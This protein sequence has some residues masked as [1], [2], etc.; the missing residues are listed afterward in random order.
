MSRLQKATLLIILIIIADQ[1][2]K[3]WVKTHMVEGSS[4]HVFGNWF[5]ILFTENEGAAFGW[6]VGGKVGKLLLSIIRVILAGA[7]IWYLPRLVKKDVSMGFV[8]G[9]AGIL[10]GAIGNI[11]DSM[12]YGLVFTDSIGR[13]AEVFPEGGGYA[14]FLFGHVVDMLYFPLI[15]GHFPSWLPIWG[16]QDFLFFRF[17]F[18]I[19]DSAVCV[20]IFYILLF[21]RKS[22]S[23][24]IGQENE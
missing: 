7:I 19:A 23:K 16:G 1:V 3:I 21:E 12:F 8:L 18:N 15:E 2:F 9:V 20:G 24:V 10:A 11:I 22:L 14:P 17:I 5:Q 6:L 4:I 13:I